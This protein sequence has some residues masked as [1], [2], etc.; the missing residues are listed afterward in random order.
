[1]KLK[2]KV[3]IALAFLIVC[4]VL[5]I[6]ASYAWFAL[7]LNPEVTSVD[8]NVGA[9]GSLEIALLND[10]T[11]ADPVLIRAG[12]GSSVVEQDVLEA[13]QNW[14]N[15]IEL[16]DERYG[17]GK[18]SLLPARLNATVNEDDAV[19][20]SRNLL[21]VADFGIDGRISI[22]SADTV[23]ATLDGD[24][25]VYYVD[26]QRYGVRAVGTVSHLS[27]QQ[28][29]LANARSLVRSHTAAASR[30]VKHT[31]RDQGAGIMDILYKHYAEGSDS[32]TAKDVTAVRNLAGGLL[33]ALDYVD[34]ALRQGIIGVA[35]S[36]IVDDA[37][38]EM[39]CSVI[40]NTNLPLSQILAYV[41]S[42][43]PGGFSQWANQI[44]G[45]RLNVRMVAAKC[46]PLARDCSWAEI[47]PL[48][49]VLLDADNAFLGETKLSNPSVFAN[50]VQGDVVTLSAD[51]GVMAQIAPY[52]GN[53][54]AIS[55]W[56]KNDSIE[57]RTTDTEK[58]P[59]LIRIETILEDS[60]AATGGWTRAKLDDTFGFAVDMAFR[61]NRESELLLQT[62]SAMRVTENSEIPEIQG[63][64]SYMRFSSE[65]MDTQ[66]LLQLMDTIRIGFLND[67]NVLVAVA[68]L[69][70]TSYEEQNEGVYAPLYLY[71][72]TLETDG[73]MTIGER[74]GENAPILA[75]PKN[76]PEVLTVIVWLDGDS[77][78]N[79]IV[80]DTA[81]QSMSGVLNLQF[82]SS[83]DL[84][85]TNGNNQQPVG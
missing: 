70:I 19:C 3:K 51:A 37:E 26:A 85:P 54:S 59:H 81:N 22:L 65:N 61:C 30:V 28:I 33:E 69:N 18:I 72:Y 60:D 6:S 9:N 48:L 20:V 71:D 42:S 13:N 5:L 2:S 12:V 40:G 31:W 67:R 47:E 45:M 53:Y 15:V 62:N 25:F 84:L 35:A 83:A 17:L 50:M 80:S 66:Q 7:S 57:L 44:D 39:L 8:T 1:M 75:L 32:F 29:A 46:V 55:L 36:Q 49:D 73:S 76:S 43:V 56:E 4:L 64:G 63:G 78:D 14:G 11:Y 82:S 24:D 16:A 21:K 74:C 58:V 41:G 79:S 27:A 68:K 38:F 10:R 23:S 77:V 52:I 34:A